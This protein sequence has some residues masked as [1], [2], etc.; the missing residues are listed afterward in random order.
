M[1]KDLTILGFKVLEMD[2]SNG[3]V[4]SSQGKELF[5]FGDE[6]KEPIEEATKLI[7]NILSELLSARK[8]GKMEPETINQLIESCQKW[9]EERNHVSG[10]GTDKANL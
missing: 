8:T 1:R 9:E 7:N 3:I 4:V 5:R 6:K 2:D 10:K